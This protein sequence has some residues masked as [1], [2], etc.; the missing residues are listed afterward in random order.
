VADFLD[1]ERTEYKSAF[2]LFKEIEQQ[3]IYAFFSES[4][5]NTASYV[6]RK[7]VPLPQFK[8]LMSDL[9]SHIKILP[10]TNA[11]VE[12]AYKNAKNDL[13]DAVLY[14]IALNGKMDYFITSDSKDFKKITH[15]LL[16]V[17]SAK[18]MLDILKS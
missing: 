4:V 13:E 16:P 7:V 14:Q 11:I 2:E 10:C 9:I 5:I 8:I 18:K 17:V 3:N 6:L 12:Q 1:R 15:P